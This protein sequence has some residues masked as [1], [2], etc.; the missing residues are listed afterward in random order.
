MA[1]RPAAAR[2]QPPASSRPASVRT[3]NTR[4]A[5]MRAVAAGG[6]RSAITA[7]SLR[8]LF[9]NARVFSSASTEAVAVGQL[10]R[11][12][13]RVG[14]RCWA[15]GVNYNSDPVW[16][17]ISTP[18]AGYVPAFNMAAHFAP[19]PRVPHCTSPAFRAV[20]NGLDVDLHIRAAPVHLSGSSMV[21]FRP[22][23]AR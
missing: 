14:V 21:I 9:G 22:S 12:G 6:P 8:T 3:A 13:T 17:D 5:S 7:R 1:S 15:T 10:G 16:C 23:A 18:V 4:A 19:A 20:F 2:Q 11:T